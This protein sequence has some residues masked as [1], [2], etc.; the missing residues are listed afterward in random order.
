[1]N[2]NKKIREIR[3]QPENVRMKY[4]YISVTLS[5]ILVIVIWLFSLKLE[6]RDINSVSTSTINNVKNIQSK[7][8]D[9]TETIKPPS[10]FSPET[11]S[12]NNINKN[13]EEDRE[14]NSINDNQ[15]NQNNQSI[16]ES[17]K[18]NTQNN[19]DKIGN[20]D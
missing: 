4:V 17:E 11:E 14:N 2:I 3:K 12:K 6:L 9:L 13:E 15:F 16:N 1:M 20:L 19:E 5:M 10:A 7:N 18:D 8:S